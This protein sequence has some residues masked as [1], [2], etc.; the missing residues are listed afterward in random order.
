MPLLSEK[1]LLG[2]IRRLLNG[3]SRLSKKQAGKLGYY[4]LSKPRRCPEDPV[5]EGFMQYA[6]V[7][8]FTTDDG[9]ALCTY[10]WPGDGPTVLLLHGWESYTGR[11]YAFYEPLRAAGYDIWAFDAPAHGRSAGR[12]FNVLMYSEALTRFLAERD[13]VP[14]HWICHSAGGMAAIYNLSQGS[15]YEPDQLVCMAVPGELSDFIDKFCEIIGVREGVKEGIDLQFQR[16]LD[17][18]FSDI[19]FIEFAKEL[20]V[21]GL[22][23]H[24]HQ[25]ELAPVSGAEAMHYNWRGSSLVTTHGL[26][27]S[28][29][30]ESIPTTVLDYLRHARG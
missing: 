26:G 6:E 1:L 11:W 20:R 2:G 5:S 19:S 3:T 4:I 24:D 30:G 16:K 14:Q 27:H 7:G 29:T 21:P 8:S 10:H 28:L 15:D 13:T 17:R 22:I 25:D 12:R 23:V 18:S 9:I